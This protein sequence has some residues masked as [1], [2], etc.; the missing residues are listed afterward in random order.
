MTDN[1]MWQGYLIQ[2]NGDNH[3]INSPW[4]LG[5]RCFWL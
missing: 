4:K 1:T 3:F 5:M 2:S